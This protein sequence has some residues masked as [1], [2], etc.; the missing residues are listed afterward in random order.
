MKSLPWLGPYMWPTRAAQ[1]G[2][3]VAGVRKQR[4]WPPQIPPIIQS[5]VKKGVPRGVPNKILEKGRGVYSEEQRATTSSIGS[6]RLDV[7]GGGRNQSLSGLSKILRIHRR[8]RLNWWRG[9]G[10]TAPTADRGRRSAG[11]ANKR[12]QSYLVSLHSGGTIKKGG[13]PRRSLE[14]GARLNSR[15]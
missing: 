10:R 12:F 5:S 6:V 7:R 4:S 8:V 11:A 3:S 14:G 13:G 2:A 15:K 1:L 9:N